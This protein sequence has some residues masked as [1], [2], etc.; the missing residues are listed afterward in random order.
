MPG[1]E[2]VIVKTIESGEDL[3][4]TYAI[5]K[6]VRTKALKRN[7]GSNSAQRIIDA[8][9]NSKGYTRKDVYPDL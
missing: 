2:E 9:R 6:R 5:P 3:S 4:L 1:N 7:F 8:Y